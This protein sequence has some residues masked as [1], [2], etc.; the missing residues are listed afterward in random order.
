MAPESITHL[1]DEENTRHLFRLLDS[2][3]AVIGVDG[4][5]EISMSPD[6]IRIWLIPRLR[7]ELTDL[8]PQ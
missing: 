4:D 1:K 8:M 2:A 6:T 7:I 5:L 3:I